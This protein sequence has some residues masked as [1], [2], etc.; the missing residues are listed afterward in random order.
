LQCGV[1]VLTRGSAAEKAAFLFLLYDTERRGQ[2]QRSEFVRFISLVLYD[3]PRDPGDYARAVDEL[4]AEAAP[5]HEGYLTRDEWTD[6]AVARAKAGT[7]ARHPLLG[8]LDCVAAAL[9]PDPGLDALAAHWVESASR[10][11]MAASAA[12]ATPA[13][14]QYRPARGTAS[15]TP[16]GAA[17]SSFGVA[18]SGGPPALTEGEAAAVAALHAALKARSRSGLLDAPALAAALAPTAPPALCERFFAACDTHGNGTLSGAELAAGLAVLLAADAHEEHAALLFRMFDGDRDGWMSTEEVAALVETATVCGRIAAAAAPRP[19]RRGHAASRAAASGST[20]A[21]SPPRAGSEQGKGGSGQAGADAAGASVLLDTA[22]GAVDALEVARLTARLRKGAL[23]EMAAAT[24]GD[25]TALDSVRPARPGHVSQVAVVAWVRRHPEML[26]CLSLLQ[27]AARVECGVRPAAPLQEAAVI[28]GCCRRFNGREP[29]AE[30]DVWHVVP[31]RWWRGWC[32]FTGYR[33]SNGSGGAGGGTVGGP[34]EEVPSASPG[35]DSAGQLGTSSPRTGLASAKSAALAGPAAGAGIGKLP[36]QAGRARVAA[37]PGPIPTS[38][39]LVPAADIFGEEVAAPA[40]G[41]SASDA[42]TAAGPAAANGTVARPAPSSVALLRPGLNVGLEIQLVPPRAWRALSQWYGVSGPPLP[43]RVICVPMAGGDRAAVSSLE[44]EAPR[45]GRSRASSSA[46]GAAAAAPTSSAAADAGLL[47]LELYPLWFRLSRLAPPPAAE[48]GSKHSKSSGKEGGSR[49]GFSL[50]GSSSSTGGGSSGSGSGADAA[51]AARRGQA[52]RVVPAG[53]GTSGVGGG[54]GSMLSPVSAVLPSSGDASGAD[55]AAGASPLPTHPPTLL[56]VL[57]PTSGSGGTSALQTAPRISR[58][59]S[60]VAGTQVFICSK[61]ATVGELRDAVAAALF[62]KPERARLWY[63][64]QTPSVPLMAYPHARAAAKAAAAGPVPAHSNGAGLPPRSGRPA[65]SPSLPPLPGQAGTLWPFE[66]LFAPGASAARLD[67]TP[68]YDGADVLADLQSLDGAWTTVSQGYAALYA[69]LAGAAA[70]AAAASA[71]VPTARADRGGARRA[72]EGTA[73]GSGTF[74]GRGGDGG[75][76]AT[77]S[78]ST[79]ALATPPVSARSPAGFSCPFPRRPRALVGFTNMGN[80]CYFNAA[81]QCVLHTPLLARYFLSG[82]WAYDCNTA[83]K[84]GTGGALAAAYAELMREAWSAAPPRGMAAVALTGRGGGSGGAGVAPA[85]APRRIKSVLARAASRFEGNEQHDAQDALQTLLSTLNEDLNRVP[86]PNKPYIEQPDSEGRPDG[87]V[88]EEWWCNHLRREQSI[89]TSLFTGQFK[90]VLTCESC[91]HA[92]ARFEPFTILSLPLPEPRTRCIVVAV[93]LAGGRHRPLVVPARVAPTGT[94]GDLKAAVAA[95]VRDHQQRVLLLPPAGLGGGSGAA[96]AVAAG[97]A[98]VAGAQPLLARADSHRGDASDGPLAVSEQRP[99][100]PPLPH[101]S[102]ASLSP[103]EGQSGF[104]GAGVPP[105]PDDAVRLVSPSG[106]DLLLVRVIGHTL[107]DTEPLEDGRALTLIREAEPCALVMYQTAPDGAYRTAHRQRLAAARERRTGCGGGLPEWDVG[108]PVSAAWRGHSGRWYPARITAVHPPAAVKEAAASADAGADSDEDS[109]EE[110]AALQT[111]VAAAV[112]A[113][114]DGEVRTGAAAATAA[115]GGADKTVPSG[116]DRRA[117]FFG[118]AGISSQGAVAGAADEGGATNV[119]PA[120]TRFTVAFEDG[121]GEETLPATSIMP[122]VPVPLTL[123]LVHRTYVVA[124][125]GVAPFGAVANGGGADDEAA[126]GG[127]AKAAA[128]A[129]ATA[130]ANAG[131]GGYG[132]ST[133]GE[134]QYLPSALYSATYFLSPLQRALFGVPLLLRCLPADTTPA[135]VYARVARLCARFVRRSMQPA[136]WGAAGSSGEGIAADAPAMSAPAPSPASVLSASTP[137]SAAPADEVSVMAAWGFALKRVL[138]AGTSCSQCSWLRHCAGCLLAPSSSTTLA[139]V[140]LGDWA[141]LAIEW[142]PALLEARYDRAEAVA[143]DFH[144]SVAEAAAAEEGPLR[145]EQC[146]DVFS[147]EER[148][149]EP[150]F[151]PKCSRVKRRVRAGARRGGMAGLRASLA[152]PAASGDTDVATT[153]LDSFLAPSPT[154]TP[155]PTPSAPDAAAGAPSDAAWVEEEDIEMRVQSKR[156]EVWR[157]PPV[158][159]V[160]LKR[161]QHTAYVR[162][163][164]HNL[165]RFPISGLSLAPYLARP[166]IA[167]PPPD[168]TWWRSLGGRLAGERDAG[169]GAGACGAAAAAAG[170]AGT[171]IL[172]TPGLGPVAAGLTAR[173]SPLLVAAAGVPGAGTPA[174]RAVKFDAGGSAPRGTAGSGEPAPHH[175]SC[176][177]SE[178]AESGDGDGGSSGGPGPGGTGS[179]ASMAGAASSAVRGAPPALSLGGAVM[180]ATLPRAPS[181]NSSAAAAAAPARAATG[182]RLL[183]RCQHARALAAPALQS[184][185]LPG[186][187]S[188]CR[189][190][191]PALTCTAW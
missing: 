31:M 24:V 33:D 76:S 9:S 154:V 98:A 177:D 126:G 163:K 22:T 38:S 172:K 74:G 21:P 166:R 131:A 123:Q 145:L 142:D 20:G 59:C 75:G 3:R 94:I 71:A 13:L 135:G 29:G 87:L 148:L 183:R 78:S 41:S 165:V 73:A 26:A 139:Q 100:P 40:A 44:L 25:M 69:A 115:A 96:V 12:L 42:A 190:R 48:G 175:G 127:S 23:A 151:C 170:V 45:A 28:A 47:E 70:A 15:S 112:H 88:A 188:C 89:V 138:P 152:A 36:G 39:L 18:R 84:L 35:L 117:A 150:G 118:P 79:T 137:A 157:V 164:L 104:A 136:A 105:H 182:A 110:A 63:R 72:D 2:L 58:W 125:A 162:R 27:Q 61:V 81:L 53:A 17:R 146:M 149:D 77:S 160:Q 111:L 49:W 186:F 122:R 153:T 109:A 141:T 116:R 91:G 119:P 176:G 7:W 62:V 52:G 113:D 1:A 134:T 180:A 174:K 158:L 124:G 169:S 80:T 189:A 97:A 4:F 93:V 121:D 184:L 34:Q 16:S 156:I 106:A 43:R 102:S 130:A 86:G 65:S 103:S 92:S 120:G 67:D 144:S 191:A 159:V 66:P 30:G 55:T 161:F 6:W 50:L 56:P 108:A 114:L 51:A 37:E 5:R 181:S 14:L 32:A 179:T 82:E 60:G 101:A 140:R 11:G 168:L 185:R 99:S 8:W 178:G 64:P 68:L 155:T 90:S 19:L 46:S 147:R 143:K 128:A 10:D 57:A 173:G 167:Q 129:S 187:H 132:A 95:L 107:R 85:I 83:A 171:G 133:L 54:H